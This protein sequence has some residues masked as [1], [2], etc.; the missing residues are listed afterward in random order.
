[1]SFSPNSFLKEQG[2]IIKVRSIGLF[3]EPDYQIVESNNG[4]S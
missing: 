3:H 1:M 2:R 4:N